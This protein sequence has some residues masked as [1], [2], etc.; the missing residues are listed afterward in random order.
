M[1]GHILYEHTPRTCL[2]GQAIHPVNQATHYLTECP[3]RP[4]YCRFCHESHLRDS[5]DYEHLRD[6]Q[7]DPVDRFEGLTKHESVCANK[8]YTCALCQEYVMARYLTQH[9]YLNHQK[10]RIIF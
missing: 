9:Y 4:V 1:D 6:F 5:S 10:I 3:K 2:C 7:Q 8:T